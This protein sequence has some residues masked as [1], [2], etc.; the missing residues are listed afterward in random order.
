VCIIALAIAISH[1]WGNSWGKLALAAILGGAVGNF[2]DRLALGE[3]IDMFEFEFVNFAIF[4]IADVFI[5]LGGIVFIV[6]FF[7][8]S[9]PSEEEPEA[10]TPAEKHRTLTP[11][12]ETPARTEPRPHTVSAPRRAVDVTDAEDMGFTVESILEEYYT[13]QIISG[14]DDGNTR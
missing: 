8:K 11:R 5:T 12:A 14:D 3:V 9:Q 10:E 13:G 1:Y 6:T 7:I 2:I 4:N